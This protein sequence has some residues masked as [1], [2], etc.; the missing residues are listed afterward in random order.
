MLKNVA[1]VLRAWNMR[2]YQ[3]RDLKKRIDTYLSG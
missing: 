1:K 2:E 3:L